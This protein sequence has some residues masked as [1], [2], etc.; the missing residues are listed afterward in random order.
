[1]FGSGAVF[2]ADGIAFA[3]G[4]WRAAGVLVVAGGFEGVAAQPG[5][6]VTAMIHKHQ[7]GS[8]EI[9][10]LMQRTRLSK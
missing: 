3:A 8:V 2:E 5:W 1:M 10:N 9:R 4:V 6:T 7:A